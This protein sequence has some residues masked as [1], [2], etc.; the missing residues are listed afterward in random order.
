[1]SGGS[2]IGVIESRVIAMRARREMQARRK[3][4]IFKFARPH[5]NNVS[6]KYHRNIN[7]NA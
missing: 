4:E 1:M 5:I 7:Q 3:A 6:N 2:N